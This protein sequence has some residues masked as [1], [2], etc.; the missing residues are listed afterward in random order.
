MAC[1]SGIYR[2]KLWRLSWAEWCSRRGRS[3]EGSGGVDSDLLFHENLLQ[4]QARDA[5][6]IT[7]E[8]L[9]GTCLPVF[10]SW[11]WSARDYEKVWEASNIRRRQRIIQAKWVQGY[12]IETDWLWRQSRRAGVEGPL[13]MEK[14]GK[15]RELQDQVFAAVRAFI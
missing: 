13:Q 4:S 12:D 1:R 3:R 8:T 5:D 14:L 2:A 6:D 7:E 9:L 11:P 10:S 15:D